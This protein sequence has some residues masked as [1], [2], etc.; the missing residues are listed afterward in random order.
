MRPSAVLLLALA[1][2]GQVAHAGHG[3]SRELK[4]AR[5][6]AEAETGGKAVGARRVSLNGTHVRNG[7]PGGVE[8]LVRMPGKQDGWRCLIDVDTMK[9]R[10]KEPI[11]NPPARVSG[12]G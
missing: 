5:A 7:L 8:V 12:D 11:P 2:P 4:A 3:R 1:L 9:L 6:L 10:R